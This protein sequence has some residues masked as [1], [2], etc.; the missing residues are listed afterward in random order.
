[1]SS[2]AVSTTATYG[3]FSGE[4]YGGTWEVSPPRPDDGVTEVTVVVIIHEI[5]S[6]KLKD[7][8]TREFS[9]A[10]RGGLPIVYA[11]QA[12]STALQE[13]AV[14]ALTDWANKRNDEY[15]IPF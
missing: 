5:G 9:L 15:D 3:V 4:T 12:A 11:E 13:I 2:M 6:V 14:G 1:M 10:D 8:M 7:P